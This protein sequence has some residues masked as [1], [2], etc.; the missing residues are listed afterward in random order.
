MREL[1]ISPEERG[2]ERREKKPF[3]V[4]NYD[5][6]SSTTLGPTIPSIAEIDIGAE[7]SSQGVLFQY[8]GSCLTKEKSSSDILILPKVC[9]NFGHI[10][11]AKVEKV[12]FGSNMY[13]G[14]F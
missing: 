12:L 14:I 2:G 7:I 1:V 11:R 9:R 8:F 4:A 5:Y 3:I 6:A 10:S 13:E